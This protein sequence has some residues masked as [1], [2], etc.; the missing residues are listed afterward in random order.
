VHPWKRELIKYQVK[1]ALNKKIC[2][3]EG[4]FSL[5]KQKLTASQAKPTP[6]KKSYAF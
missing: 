2:L 5:W 4:V 6:G 1:P 3:E